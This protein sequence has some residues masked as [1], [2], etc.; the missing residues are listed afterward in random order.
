MKTYYIYGHWTKDTNELFY[1]GVGTDGRLTIEHNRNNYWA[2]IANKH[3]YEAHIVLDGFTDRDEAVKEEVRLQLL[4]K[5]RACLRYGD[6]KA[7]IVSEETRKRISE[8]NKGR[9]VSKEARRKISKTLK[10]R[11]CGELHPMYGRNHTKETKKKIGE[12]QKGSNNNKARKI[13]NCKGEIFCTIGEAALA[14]SLSN[15]SNISRACKM[16]KTAGKY[17]DGTKIKWRYY[18]S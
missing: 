6:G 2:N 13:V 18:V 4:N 5:P 9:V 8:S 17:S 16:G 11:F 1:I 12:A 14:Y 10:G 7:S 3:G 15:Q